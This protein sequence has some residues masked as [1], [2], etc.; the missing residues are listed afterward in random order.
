MASYT[1]TPA[2]PDK[3]EA[4]CITWF[5]SSQYTPLPPGQY[6]LNLASEL[7][8]VS[9]TVILEV[10][11]TTILYTFPVG[12]PMGI[13]TVSVVGPNY[14]ETAAN[15][16]ITCF[17]EGSEILCIKND[18]EEYVKVEDLDEGDL[19]KTYKNTPK[20]IKH[21]MKKV[22]KNDNSYSKICKLSGRLNQTKD[23]YLTGGHSM[24]VDELTEKQEKDTLKV[25]KQVRKI[26]DKCLLLCF[27]DD[28]NEKIDDENE[29]TIYHIA[30]ENDD[31]DGQYGIY[32]NGLLTESIS[33]NQYIKCNN[34][35][36]ITESDCN[37]IL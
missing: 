33:I 34:L 17:V 1:T 28:A 6:A 3:Y 18:K 30:L 7:Y 23:L 8:Y 2:N 13:Y 29:Y 15:L 19:V 35:L 12:L 22:Y 24:L 16:R 4:F 11:Q 5:P 27:I 32:A 10:P 14:N 20:K 21:I 9:Q 25:W 36:S 31:L 37:Y 26:E